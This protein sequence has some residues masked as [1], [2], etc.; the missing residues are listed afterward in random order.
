[1]PDTQIITDRE[2]AL[3]RAMLAFDYM[4]LDDILPDDVGYRPDDGVARRRG[5]QM[6]SSV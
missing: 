2:N 4:A 3:Y 6:P 5:D 1:M